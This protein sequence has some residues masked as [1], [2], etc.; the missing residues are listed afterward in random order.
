V[1][2]SGTG[3]YPVGGRSRNFEY[4]NIWE[5]KEEEEGGGE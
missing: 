1:K 3:E 4:F 2:W 5:E